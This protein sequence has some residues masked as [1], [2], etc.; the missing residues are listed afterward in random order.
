MARV[1]A[2]GLSNSP[3]VRQCTLLFSPY[4]IPDGSCRR[5]RK[6]AGFPGRQ[7]RAAVAWTEPQPDRELLPPKSSVLRVVDREGFR[8]PAAAMMW[9]DA[10]D[11]AIGHR[12][13]ADLDESD[14]RQQRCSGT[15]IN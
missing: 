7:F 12:L 9:I 10:A 14:D 11:I 4:A 1:I 8:R 2:S 13:H 3:G 6:L 5:P 15:T